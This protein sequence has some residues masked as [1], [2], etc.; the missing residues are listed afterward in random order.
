MTCR[1]GPRVLYGRVF[2]ASPPRAGAHTVSALVNLAGAKWEAGRGLVW[3]PGPCEAVA[4]TFTV[5]PSA[6]G[7]MG[8]VSLGDRRALRGPGLCPWRGAREGCESPIRLVFSSFWCARGAPGVRQAVAI[9]AQGCVR[10]V[11]PCASARG[12]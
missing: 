8:S 7:G 11:K 9:G 6:Y 5:A 4:L 10:M 2:V 1:V 12:L 3:G